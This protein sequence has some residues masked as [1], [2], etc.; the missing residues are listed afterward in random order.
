MSSFL[1]EIGDILTG[2]LQSAID[3]EVSERLEAIN[4]PSPTV[5]APP[6][7]G[8]PD[9]AIRTED[10]RTIRAGEPGYFLSQVEQVPP[11][12]WASLAVSVVLIF[13]ALRR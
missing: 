12:L 8:G 13:V 3:L 6:P 5:V 10:G 7:R 11:L 9:R 1:G 2:G 4:R